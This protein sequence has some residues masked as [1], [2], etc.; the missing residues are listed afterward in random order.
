VGENGV[1]AQLTRC[2]SAVAELL[3]LNTVAQTLSKL[4]VKVGLVILSRKQ[5]DE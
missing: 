1:H 4:E 3:V 5:T 2:F